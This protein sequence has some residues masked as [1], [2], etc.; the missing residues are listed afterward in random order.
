[1]KMIDA[2]HGGGQVLRTALGMAALTGQDIHI[3]HI[4][5]NRPKPGLQP[6][7]LA[8]VKA[9]AQI[10]GGQA[11]GATIGASELTLRPNSVKGGD[12]TFDIG[13]AGSTSLLLQCILPPLL[14]ADEDSVVR[15][16][17]GTDVP[18][19]PPSLFLQRV[20]L[21]AIRAMGA[22]V[23]LKVEKHGFYPKGGGGLEA[24]ITPVG[25][26][27][28]LDWLEKGKS[29]GA[30][31]TVLSCNLPAHV[32]EREKTVLEKAGIADVRIDSPDA[33]G[34]G[35]VAF[36]QADYAHA[37]MGFDALGKIGKS[38][39]SVAQ[40]ALQKWQA[41]GKSDD[42]CEPHLLDQLLLYAALA[43]GES[44]IRLQYLSEHAIS[45]LRVLHEL[46]ETE[47]AFDGNVLTVHG[48]TPV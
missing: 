43:E 25:R 6:Q 9:I 24:R 16:T 27:E 3:T 34:V 26:L 39:E 17:G 44:R 2:G 20:F 18:F 32:A 21:P 10:S 31:A 40:E 48:H 14:F 41:F 5:Q 4:R 37:A 45:N 46:M 38:A 15:I 30:H 1:M 28:P 42:A 19:A 47:H 29:L 12:F 8:C 22:E 23:T 7:H 11:V 36:I 35:N 13:T 33:V